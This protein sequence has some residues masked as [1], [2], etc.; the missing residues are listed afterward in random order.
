MSDEEIL[1]ALLC[2]SPSGQ[3]STLFIN[4]EGYIQGALVGWPASDAPRLRRGP[5]LRVT[6]E[7]YQNHVNF[8]TG[9]A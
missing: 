8:A 3:K 7:E 6:E 4:G 1:I 2:Q 5:I 9:T